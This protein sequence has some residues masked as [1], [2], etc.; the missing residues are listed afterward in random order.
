M[1]DLDVFLAGRIRPDGVQALEVGVS[2]VC[3]DSYQK[4][5]DSRTMESARAHA[6]EGGNNSLNLRIISAAEIPVRSGATRANNSIDAQRAWKRSG[7]RFTGYGRRWRVAFMAFS[8]S[9][10]ALIRVPTIPASSVTTRRVGIIAFAI[11]NAENT[12]RSTTGRPS[13]V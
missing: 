9:R 6:R 5:A 4:G 1:V 11:V 12:R 8:A 13:T 3:D 10:S 7:R 2:T